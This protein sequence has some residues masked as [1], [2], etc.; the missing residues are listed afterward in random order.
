MNSGGI[1]SSLE[2][3]NITMADLMAALPFG[4][5]IDQVTIKGKLLRETF[6][7]VASKASVDGSTNFGGFLQVSGRGTCSRSAAS[8]ANI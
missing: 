4:N 1:R 7:K 2:I 8:P 5:S 3:G 6:E